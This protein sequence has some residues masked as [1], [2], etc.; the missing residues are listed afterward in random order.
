MTNPECLNQMEN[1]LIVARAKNIENAMNVVVENVIRRHFLNQKGIVNHVEKR[2]ERVI[3]KFKECFYFQDIGIVF[4]RMYVLHPKEKSPILMIF[5][6]TFIPQHYGTYFRINLCYTFDRWKTVQKE[7]FM[8][9]GCV[10]RSNMLE[11]TWLT[12]KNNYE[13]LWFAIEMNYYGRKIWDNNNGWNF[14]VSKQNH[15][16]PDYV[17]PAKDPRDSFH[18]G[19]GIDKQLLSLNNWFYYY[20]KKIEVLELLTLFQYHF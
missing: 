5:A 16:I 3:D 10:H 18:S 13:D 7:G 2:F 12:T 6:K 17:I 4:D 11:F 1:A 14:D 9:L 19:R 15:W 8:L 20:K